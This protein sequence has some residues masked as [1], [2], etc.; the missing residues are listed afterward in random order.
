[1]DTPVTHNH[2]VRHLAKT[3]RPTVV[4]SGSGMCTGGKIVNYLKAMLHDPRHNVLLVGYRVAGTPG[5]QL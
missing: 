3:A 2:M 1:M 4:I 5:R